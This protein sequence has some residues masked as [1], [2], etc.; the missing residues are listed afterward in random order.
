M[1][2]VP[3]SGFLRNVTQVVDPTVRYPRSLNESIRAG[4]PGLSQ[5]VRPKLDIFGQEIRRD[6]GGPLPVPGLTFPTGV[7]EVSGVV[8]G[9]P[10][11]NALQRTDVLVRDAQGP[12]YLDVRGVRMPLTSEQ[13]V[14]AGRQRGQLLRRV[15]DNVVD[16]PGFATLPLDRQA[17]VLEEVKRRV[18][19]KV[20]G[21]TRATLLR[22]HP[23]EVLERLV[24]ARSTERP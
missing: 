13:S 22:E 19:R 4:L 5:T 17:T 3:A 16:A 23:T 11:L 2:N 21:L 14:T 9:D 6:P 20:M 1:M 12:A 24:A 10:V 8:Q 18:N 7:P 15:L